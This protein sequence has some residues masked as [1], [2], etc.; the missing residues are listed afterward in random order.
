VRILTI[1]LLALSITTGVRAEGPGEAPPGAAVP[2][3]DPGPRPKA[4]EGPPPAVLIPVDLISA[5][6]KY[7]DGQPHRDVYGMLNQ[8]NACWSLQLSATGPQG[9]CP[10]VSA[11]IARAKSTKG[12]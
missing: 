6:Y 12:K 3:A 1:T 9:E 10:A 11:M 5:I 2:V 7:L 8:L 4:P